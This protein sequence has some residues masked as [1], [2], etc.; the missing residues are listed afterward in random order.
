MSESIKMGAA[1]SFV[2][3]IFDGVSLVCL[4]LVSYVIVNE[5]SQSYYINKSTS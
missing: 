4:F 3:I 2:E 5:D 1:G